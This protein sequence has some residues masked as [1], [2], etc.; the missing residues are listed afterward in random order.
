[1][2]NLVMKVLQLKSEIRAWLQVET[3]LGRLGAAGVL[4]ETAGTGFDQMRRLDLGVLLLVLGSGGRYRDETG[5]D[6]RLMPGDCLC[7]PPGIGHMYGREPGDTWTEAYLTFGGLVFDGWFALRTGRN[8]RLQHLGSAEIWLPRWNKIRAMEARSPAEAVRVLA[9]IHLLLNEVLRPRELES[10]GAVLLEQTRRMVETWPARSS[11]DWRH[12]AR[13]CHLSYESW[14]KVF[15]QTFGEP[16]ARFR[17][18][19]LM[20]QATDLLRRTRLSNDQ[21]AEHFG[22]GDAFHFSKMFKSVHGVGPAAWR[23]REVAVKTSYPE[24]QE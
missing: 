9:E 6:E 18:R 19:V 11:P 22:C 8:A 2:F 15:R 5:V 1:M 20:E 12:L 10:D 21:L 23:R 7:V 4:V 17:R 14:R 16:P 3:P 24:A 13:M